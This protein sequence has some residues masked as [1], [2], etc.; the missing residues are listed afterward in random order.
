[1]KRG[2]PERHARRGLVATH[3]NAVMGQ[4]SKCYIMMFF[5]S[6]KPIQMLIRLFEN[7]NTKDSVSTNL[8]PPT[9]RLVH[10]AGVMEAVGLQSSLLLVWKTSRIFL[11][12]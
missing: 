11:N 1:M 2:H 9:D 6:L 5:E 7:T 12:Q 3:C 10:N 4:S 8:L